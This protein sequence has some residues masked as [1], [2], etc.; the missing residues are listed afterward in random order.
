MR[1]SSVIGRVVAL[2]AILVAIVVVAIVLL[3]GGDN[4]YRVKARF[5]NASQ[6]VKGNLVQISGKAVGKVEKIDLTSDGQAEIR[7]KIDKDY[8]PLREGTQAIVRASSLSGIAS[9][10][11]D[12]SLP[13][14]THQRK[15]PDGGVIAQDATTTAVDLDQLF[16]TFDPKTRT[17]LRNVIHGSA[18]QYTGR[19]AQANAGFPYLNPSLVS[20]ASLS[21]EL[22]RDRPALR[23]FIGD[24]ASLV[25]DIAQRRDDL[26]GLI[27]N[28]SQTTSAIGS[29]RDE[30]ASAIQQLPGFM[31][32]S[33]TTFVNLRATLD[34][35]DPLVRE[36]KPVAKKL[37]P[38][39]AE[40]R[41][42]A[43]D[44]RPTIRDLS[45]LVRRSGAS[46]DLIE[47]TKSNV[48]LANIA[49]RNVNV[50]GKTREGAF[51]ASSKAL[52]RST[53]KLSDARPYAPDLLGWFDDF[54]HSGVI[55]ALGG[56]SRVQLGVNLFTTVNGLPSLPLLSPAQR[57]AQ[58]ASQGQTGQ[59]NRCPGALER[60]V[61]GSNSGK[62][63]PDFN[64]DPSERIP[65]K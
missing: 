55:D 49:V 3:G 59:Y 50:N 56:V 52:A 20:T 47:L 6:L 24:T 44:A 60:N 8:A 62:P 26:A 16:N 33:N 30:L 58:L 9:R 10:Y 37:R 65:G 43:R 32:R 22:T 14:G 51:P 29:R 36:S 40:L 18:N 23:R 63:T 39:L 42:L 19:G 41:P 31:R 7:L 12:L 35:L 34:D 57:I 38:F 13:S 64:C 28:L 15:I 45:K 25:G 21:Q 53:P 2:G 46:N 4:G 17:A 61:D 1:N 5:Q 11:I 27:S 54:S 48:P